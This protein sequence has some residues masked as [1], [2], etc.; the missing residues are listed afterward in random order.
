MTSAHGACG[1]RMPRPS[2][3]DEHGR[4]LAEDREPA[5]EDQRA[6][7]HPAAAGVDRE[8]RQARL[9]HGAG[10]SSGAG[11]GSKGIDRGRPGGPCDGRRP[12]ATTAAPT[13]TR[14]PPP[15]TRLSAL[16]AA[17]AVVVVG[18]AAGG[19]FAMRRAERRSL[20]RL[21]A[22]AVAGGAATI[23]GPFTLTDGD[24]TAGD[25]RRGDHR[26]DARLLRLQLL[27]RLLPDRPVA[28]R[29]RR[30]GRWRSAATTS[31]RSSSR[32][33]RSATR[34]RWSRDFAA[35]IDPALVGLTGTRRRDRRGGQGLQ[36]VL[37][38]GGDDPDYYL[39][40]HSTFTYLMAP[41]TGFLEFFR[42]DATPRAGGRIGGLLCRQALDA[43]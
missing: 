15:M 41:E 1:M 31:G 2:V 27:P 20:R 35:A 11:A 12:R 26:A 30:R 40:D 14:R 21:P 9:G 23:G 28:Q 5:Q 18:L 29:A 43:S 32:S 16:L 37:P 10:D 22:A 19:F 25:R 17:A 39:M 13:R 6:Q 38:Q 7:P 24:G 33:T 34:P 36:G 8:E 4:R 3:G 42:S